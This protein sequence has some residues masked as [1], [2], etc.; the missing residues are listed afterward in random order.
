MHTLAYISHETWPM[1]RD[2][3]FILLQLCREKNLAHN[4]T[5]LLLYVDGKFV[6]VIE[7]NKSD[8][9]QLYA[10]IKQDSRNKQVTQLIYK[11]IETRNFEKWEMGFVSALEVEIRNIAG[12]SRFL[13]PNY[14]IDSIAK[15]NDEVFDLLI[16]FRKN[17]ALE[18][19]VAT[20]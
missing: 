16:D 12:L 15:Q 10:N 19:L 17:K 11:K 4:I 20:S 3:L 9:D 1:T 5:G 2:K 14:D 6:Q 18:K 8:I 13:D 7:G